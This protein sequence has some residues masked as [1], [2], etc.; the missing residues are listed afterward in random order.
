M[1]HQDSG[2]KVTVTIDGIPLQVPKGTLLVEA[3]KLAGIEIPVYCYHTK[4]GPAGLKGCPS[5]RSRATRR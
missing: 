2:E 4:L 3:A 1:A 5:C